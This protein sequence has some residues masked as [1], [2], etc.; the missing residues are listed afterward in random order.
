ME[1]LMKSRQWFVARGRRGLRLAAVIGSILTSDLGSPQSAQSSHPRRAPLVDER[2]LDTARNVAK[3]A[4]SWDEKR[5][6]DQAL[7]LADSE[8]DLAFDDAL[9]DAADHPVP[10]TP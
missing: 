4:T 1:S 10:P 6:A 7:R 8:V 2:P 9:R 3:L 5:F